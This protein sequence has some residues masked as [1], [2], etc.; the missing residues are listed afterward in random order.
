MGYRD[1]RDISDVVT[2]AG[3][4]ITNFEPDNILD[5]QS[6]TLSGI[7]NVVGTLINQLSEMRLISAAVTYE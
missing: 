7:N 6:E 4:T 2:S 3:F 5:C 1:Q